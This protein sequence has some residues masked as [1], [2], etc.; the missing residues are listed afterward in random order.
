MRVVGKDATS[1][2]LDRSDIHQLAGQ[3]K[4]FLGLLLQAGKEFGRGFRLGLE[5]NLDTLLFGKFNGDLGVG[6]FFSLDEKIK[7]F[8]S[9]GH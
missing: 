4:G 2:I 7:M 9:P 3:F 6:N 5:F 8:Y 1:G